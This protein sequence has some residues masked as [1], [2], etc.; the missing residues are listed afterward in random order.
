MHLFLFGYYIFLILC[1][2]HSEREEHEWFYQKGASYLF[3]DRFDKFVEPIPLE[4]RGDM[5][6]A[7]H[8][9]LHGDNK[10]VLHLNNFKIGAIQWIRLSCILETLY[11]S[12]L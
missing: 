5:I 12:Y 9:R 7:Y 1:S 11:L 10:E 3:P 4:E 6:A 2:S 8:R